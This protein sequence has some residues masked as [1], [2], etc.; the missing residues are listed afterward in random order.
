VSPEEL[1]GVAEIA[2]ML[3]VVRQYV[4]RLINEDPTFPEPVAELA[5]GRVWR[6]RDVEVWARS[7][8]RTLEA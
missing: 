1:A 5:S 2:E 8:G 3:G 7:A 4:H 6:R